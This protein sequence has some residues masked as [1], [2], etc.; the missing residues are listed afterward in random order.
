MKTKAAREGWLSREKARRGAPKN[1]RGVTKQCGLR[2]GWQD[3]LVST[4]H[5][6]PL[7]PEYVGHLKTGGKPKGM[8]GDT[9]A[10]EEWRRNQELDRNRAAE[11]AERAATGDYVCRNQCGK[12]FR[13]NLLRLQHEAR[14]CVNDKDGRPRRVYRC[15]T[16]GCT[17]THVNQSALEDHERNCKHT[18]EFESPTCPSCGYQVNN[19]VMRDGV[20]EVK[21]KDRNATARW[22]SH[23]RHFRKTRMVRCMKCGEHHLIPGCMVT[24]RSM[25]REFQCSDNFLDVR[26]GSQHCRQRFPREG[27][28]PEWLDR[29]K[30]EID[31]LGRDTDSSDEEPLVEAQ[32]DAD[33]AGPPPET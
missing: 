33:D 26:M 24:P 15:K 19:K 10:A 9:I 16:P 23:V 3:H 20:L 8:R 30:R 22:M 7:H 12:S 29:W 21:G 31:D 25:G 27:G 14:E 4:K 13:T 18:Y 11:M 32:A 1:L 28:R 6:C 5:K 17:K 2:C